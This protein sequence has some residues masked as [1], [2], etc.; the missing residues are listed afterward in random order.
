M[1]RVLSILVIGAFAFALVAFVGGC[2][3]M[4]MHEARERQC[5]GSWGWAG[6][7]SC[8]T[9]PD[10]LGSVRSAFKILVSMPGRRVLMTPAASI[11]Y[12]GGWSPGFSRFVP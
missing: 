7:L 4:K 10:R 3:C 5:R 8:L 12:R 11:P 1:K 2:K 9:P 6:A